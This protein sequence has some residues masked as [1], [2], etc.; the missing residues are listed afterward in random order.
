MRRAGENRQI[1][2]HR[3]ER[4]RDRQQRET[5]DDAAPPVDP[6][7]EEGDGEARDRHAHRAGV[8]GEA[9]RRR[10]NPIGT[11]ERRQDGLRGEKIDQG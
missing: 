10:R 7:T 4:C 9:H 3:Q 11:R 1:R 6:M 5:Q 2:R 8:D